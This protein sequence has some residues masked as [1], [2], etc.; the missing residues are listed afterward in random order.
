MLPVLCMLP[1]HAS[2]VCKEHLRRQRQGTQ[3]GCRPRC[4]LRP[5]TGW[6]A[7]HVIF[8]HRG[9]L[10]Y[11][12]R[13][14]N[15]GAHR[16]GL[17]NQRCCCSR[18]RQPAGQLA[19]GH[20]TLPSTSE[21]QHCFPAQAT[22]HA[23]LRRAPASA[24]TRLHLCQGRSGAPRYASGLALP[25]MHHHH[26][27]PQAPTYLAHLPALHLFPS[28]SQRHAQLLRPAAASGSGNGA[29]AAAVKPAHVSQLASSKP[30]KPVMVSMPP[31]SCALQSIVCYASFAQ[32]SGRGYIGCL[33]MG[34]LCP[35]ACACMQA[36][37]RCACAMHAAGAS[38]VGPAHR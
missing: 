5:A 20:R 11:S 26:A 27:R 9:M 22:L 1:V 10:T 23:S 35:K 25:S 6:S 3:G 28:T 29:A 18:G 31:A 38:Q 33:P 30:T 36:A 8:A 4:Q 14:R 2:F 7:D 24:S 32:G 21:S 12:V 37:W 17:N 15:P 13:A 16:I 19:P 34:L